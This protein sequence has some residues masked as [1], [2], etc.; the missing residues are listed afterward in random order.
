[1]NSNIGIVNLEGLMNKVDELNKVPEQV[2]SRTVSDFK[3]RAPGWIASAVMERYNITKKEIVPA[4]TENKAPMNGGRLKSA[5]S[6]SITGRTI[7]SVCIIYKGRRLTPVRFN[8]TPKAP[9]PAYTL[10]AKILK[11]EKKTLGKVKRLTKKQKKNVGRNFTHQGIK[12]SGKSPVMLMHTGNR[13]S[14][15]VDFIPFQ[16]QSQRRD[17]IK[18]IKTVSLPQMVTHELVSKR[19]EDKVNE[20]LGKRFDHH[21]QQGFKKYV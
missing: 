19:I 10:K 20:E 14:D 4:K 3:S 11:G 1:M 6:I 8:M 15:G 13:Q 21:L 7:S 5:G 18:A 16:R 2:L 9:R 17:D 12:N